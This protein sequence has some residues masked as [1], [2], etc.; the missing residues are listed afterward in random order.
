MRIPGS[1]VVGVLVVVLQSAPLA[2]DGQPAGYVKIATG[3]I[4]IL[5]GGRD[6][7]AH[8][9]AGVYQD[10]ELRTGPDGHLGVTL[11]DD[12][13]ISLGP[14]SQLRLSQFAFSPG[15]GQLALVMK[16]LRGSAAFITGRIADL[17]HEAVR[18]ETPTT[19]VGVRGTHL[20][21]RVEAP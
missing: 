8:P 21:V 2:L 7:A 18:I 16:V 10:D 13:R 20:A 19:I 6:V 4:S 9:G 12:T 11:K 1:I 5:R 14:N 17:R 3:A 15:E